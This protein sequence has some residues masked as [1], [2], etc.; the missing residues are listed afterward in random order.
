MPLETGTPVIVGVSLAALI[1][2][3]HVQHAGSTVRS[4][5]RSVHHDAVPCAKQG[6]PLHR[7]TASFCMGSVV[8]RK[9]WMYGSIKTVPCIYRNWGSI[10]DVDPSTVFIVTGWLNWVEKL[11]LGP[12]APGPEL[13]YSANVTWSVLQMTLQRQTSSKPKFRRT[14]A[15]CVKTSMLTWIHL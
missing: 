4:G 12:A 2:H 6:T 13:L 3:I 7:M 14:E 10:Q 5:L 8:L 11:A 9:L 15:N 1:Y